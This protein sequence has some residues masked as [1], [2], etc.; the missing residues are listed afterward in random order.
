MTKQR[1]GGVKLKVQDHTA[2]KLVTAEL[3]FLLCSAEEAVP[4]PLT[5]PLPPTGGLWRLWEGVPLIQGHAELL[6]GRPSLEAGCLGSHRHH[7]IPLTPFST[8]VY[9]R[10]QRDGR[11]S[12]GQPGASWRWLEG[13]L[14]PVQARALP[15]L[16]RHTRSPGS[17]T[18]TRSKLPQ[19]AL[20]ISVLNAW[21]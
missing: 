10:D 20:R 16:P 11:G 5:Q 12:S 2:V 19:D 14:G 15:G 21:C 1:L 6:E 8:G 7:D 4:G 18:C 17:P 9:L 13:V 3:T